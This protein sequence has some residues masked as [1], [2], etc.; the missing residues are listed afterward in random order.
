MTKPTIKAANNSVPDYT[1]INR[2]AAV[3][4][5]TKINDYDS[6]R[7]IADSDALTLWD[8]SNKS[9]SHESNEEHSAA[10]TLCDL[11]LDR[12]EDRSAAS[13]IDYE[14]SAHPF[15]TLAKLCYILYETIRKSKPTKGAPY[16][17]KEHFIRLSFSTK[18]L[19]WA[20]FEHSK[21]EL[22][23]LKTNNNK[24][25]NPFL[26]SN[27]N[28]FRTQKQPDQRQSD[29]EQARSGPKCPKILHLQPHHTSKTYLRNS[30][31][32]S[33]V[34]KKYTDLIL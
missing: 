20:R 16:N 22:H 27:K 33:V 8:S 3:C 13:T 2:D 34:S 31:Q 24:N 10:S 21:D 30:I 7:C 26:Q 15:D 4:S 18:A 32:N 25:H 29:S 28:P 23:Q 5:K 11:S 6:L 12:N 14:N 17:P 19:D 1:S 9:I